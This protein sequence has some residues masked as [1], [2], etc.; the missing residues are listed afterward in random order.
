LIDTTLLALFIPTFFLVSI[1]PGM[2]MTLAMTLGMSIGVRN[3]LWMMW[4]ELLG[5]ALVAI[6]AVIGV[7]S[8]MLKFPQFF[9]VLKIMGAAYLFYVGINMWRSK[10]KLAI[11]D[12]IQVIKINKRQ[13]F[14]Q[15]L[16]TAIA[17]PKGWA[18]M[19]SLLPPFINPSIPLT[20]QLAVLVAVILVSEFTCM[21]LYATGGKTLGRLL[22]QGDNVRRLNKVS[23]TLMILV[24][25]WLA[26][27]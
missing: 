22:T 20:T 4:G 14:N 10:G 5:V 24:A 26:A 19:V 2:C 16:V 8:V 21:L 7:S 18:F 11:S 3:T 15:G 27:S 23:G 17:N 6:L 1:T 12:A 13:L 25:L 9:N